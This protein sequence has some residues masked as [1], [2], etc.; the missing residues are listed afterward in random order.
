MCGIVGGV[1]I[2]N[3]V[4]RSLSTSANEQVHEVVVQHVYPVELGLALLEEGRAFFGRPSELASSVGVLKPWKGGTTGQLTVFLIRTRAHQCLEQRIVAENLGV[5]RIE[6]T[7]QKLID[8][9]SQDIL[10]RMDHEQGIA[11]VGKS[12]CQTLDDAQLLLK[13]TNRK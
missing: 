5:I 1:Q 6:V 4:R 7:S 8:V 13:F 10:S 12:L 11:W 3:H 9:L 2:N